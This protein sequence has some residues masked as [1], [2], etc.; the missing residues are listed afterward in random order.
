M[1]KPIVFAASNLDRASN[2]RR[3][4]SWVEARLA[5]PNSRFLPL[6]TL[7]PLVTTKDGQARLG[8][9]SR[10]ALGDIA[11][12]TCI[13]LG[14]LDETCH[15]AVDLPAETEMPSAAGSFTEVR[16]IAPQLPVTETGI[17]A[18]ARSMLDWHAR[19]GFCSVCGQPTQAVEGGY[20]RLC[21]NPAC[22]ASHFPRTD[23]V[24]IMLVLRGD[25]CLL[26][27]SARFVT[28]SYSALAGFLEPGETI[29]DAVRREVEEESGIR[30]G[31]VRYVTCQPWP[32]PSSL[33]I[34]CFAEALTDEIKV[35][36]D[37]LEDARWFSRAEVQ[38][39]AQNALTP[40]AVPRLATP[41]AI[42]HQLALRWLAG[43]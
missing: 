24:V 14:L 33:M 12:R 43:E 1:R 16:P 31:A 10:A 25:Y 28:G 11:G 8:W 13:M 34:G 18:Q 37:E 17:L 42:A 22:K 41:M 20:S 39:M 23:P 9:Q 32:F 40:S 19:H 5:D 38:Q 30:A 26:G 15:F 7:K 3:D 27:R 36:H 29:E 35:D 2:L 6:Q 4:P 21:P